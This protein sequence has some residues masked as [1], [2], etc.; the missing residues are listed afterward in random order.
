MLGLIFKKTDSHSKK[1]L[2]K[3]ECPHGI[4]ES[5]IKR[6]TD[7]NYFSS[8]VCKKCG[9]GDFIMREDMKL[10]KQIDSRM[11]RHTITLLSGRP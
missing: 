4:Y 6:D 7:N 1:T 10:N 5:E 11:H 3:I 8:F 2:Y 9:G